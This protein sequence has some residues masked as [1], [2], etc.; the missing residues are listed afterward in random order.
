MN[1]TKKMMMSVL[2]A[3]VAVSTS[4]CNDENLPPKPD[5]PDCDEWEWDASTGTYVC[6]DDDSSHYR[7]HFYGGRYYSSKRKLQQSE[8]YKSYQRS[9]EFKARAKSGIGS[10]T[11]GSFF[12]G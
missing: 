4:A 7:H 6:D 10:G 9:A 5:D 12:G 2:T 3:L 8:S 1:K 11:K